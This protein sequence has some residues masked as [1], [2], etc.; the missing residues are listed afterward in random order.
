MRA[1]ITAALAVLSTA[2]TSHGVITQ[3][4]ALERPEN[5]FVGLFR[6]GSAVAIGEHYLLTA[7]HVGG[8]S[9]NV[10]NVNGD[11]FIVRD[12]TR[13]PDADVALIEVSQPL[14]GW[15]TVTSDLSR[16]D[17]LVFGGFGL[18]E[19]RRIRR[20]Y[21]WSNER[22]EVWGENELD[23][24]FNDYGVFDFDRRGRDMLESEAIFTPGDS[25]TGVFVEDQETGLLDLAGIAV[26]ITGRYGQSRFGSLGFFHTLDETLDFFDLD[27][28]P[29]VADELAFGVQGPIQGVSP[30]PAPG[31]FALLGIAGLATVR[32]RR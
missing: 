3:G 21:R 10:V 8:Q 24:T 1:P 12:V 20:G 2:G 22:G 31:A 18:T 30:V 9:R 32:R 17:R 25:G 23:Y 19:E 26:G 15:H 16:G 13:H 6:G 7:A 28:T 11:R 5:A 14:P 29:F 4:E 27:L